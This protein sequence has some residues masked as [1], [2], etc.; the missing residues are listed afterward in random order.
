VTDTSAA[1]TTIE[2]ADS[3]ALASAPR[4]PRIGES[5]PRPDGIP[6]A[7]GRFA[8]SADL[9]AE[10]MLWGHTLRSPHP[11]ARIVSVDIA[12]ALRIPGVE[13]VL[14]AA[15]VP[16]RPTYGLEHHDT[17]VFA[18]DVVRYQGEPIAC[19]AADH[20]ETAR[21]AA[22][23]IEVEYEV[24]APLV[25]AEAA[26]EAPPIHPD[27]NV[28][29]HLVIRHGDVG[30]IGDVVVEG[31]YEVGMQDQAPLGTEA[32]MAVPAEDGGI[33]LYIATQ[34][35]HVDHSQ[36]AASTGLPPEKVRLQLAGV[37]GAFGAREDVSLQIHLSL[38][39]LHTGRPVKMVY[40]RAESFFGHVHRHP[41]TLW[42]RHHAAADGRLVK[43]ESR[44]VFDGGAYAS[45]SPA[46]IGNAA[47]FAVGPYFTP[48]ALIE[49]WAV[50]TN[51]P[52]CGAMR[53]FGAVQTCFAHEAQMDKLATALG[54]DPVELRLK[55]ALKTGDTLP[56]GQVIA[57]AAPVAEVIR[58]VA[59]VPDGVADT[60]EGHAMALPGGAGRT[61]QTGDVVRGEGFAV[62]FKNIAFS[63]GFDDFSTARVRLD[64]GVATVTTAC[65]EVGQ[66]FVTIAQQF[67]REVLGVDEVVL[68]PADT[69]IGSAGSTSASRQT[70]MSG[71]AVKAAAEAVRDRMLSLVAAEHGLDPSTLAVV[72]DRIVAPD[73]ALDILVADALD[74][75]VVEETVE[76]HHAPT[77]PLDDDGQGHAHLSF[78]FVAHRAVVDVD[79][80]L[81]LCRLVDLVTS[82]DVGKVLNP[83]QLLGQLEGG[84]AQG[85]GL[86]LMEEILVADGKVRNASFTDYLIPTALDL[87]DLRVGDLVE[88]PE[89][90][91]PFGAKGVGEPPTISSTPAVV[92]AVRAATGLAL[93]RTPVRPADIALAARPTRGAAST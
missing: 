15:D 17:P 71:G 13:A 30:A 12:P 2:T 89:P 83:L 14:T 36:V 77:F 44:L 11:S 27:G 46:V 28:V 16:G 69:T 87:P 88:Q 7:Q 24:T 1:V 67:T 52:P 81:G 86:A 70:W 38:L 19:V 73:G 66:G 79:P 82:Q 60:L 63:E 51:N 68:A 92:A 49:G 42:Y 40:D 9:W 58:A 84:A 37:G 26:I 65:A 45:S 3:T 21:R 55:N 35:L 64:R 29:R 75:Q 22:E 91:A 43:V 47:C 41:A 10:G 50:R 59:A 74:D 90:G 6:K 5:A 34:W 93:D 56:T 20:P 57:G 25:D 54:M 31:T 4:A 53:G 18:S 72:G 61:A 62:G 33:D 78:A 85:V 23:A 76:Y 39:A 8:Y 32:G 80:E 48:N